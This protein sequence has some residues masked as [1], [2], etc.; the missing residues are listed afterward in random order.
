VI[1]PLPAHA[2]GIFFYTNNS[3]TNR[4]TQSIPG[5]ALFVQTDASICNADPATVG[6]VPVTIVSQLTG[7]SET[8]TAVE[9]GP[10]TG[11]FRILPSVPTANAATHIVASGDGILEV[12]RNDTVT[13]TITA[14]GGI[15]VSATTTLLVDPSAPSTTPRT[16][17][18]HRRRHRA[19]DRHHSAPA[20][21]AAPACPAVVFQMDGITPAPSVVVTGGRRFL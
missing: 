21:A 17:Q 11:I 16:N 9:T 5:N 12:L 2:A 20:T 1:L 10:N 3:Y 6:T 7:D 13:A 4:A 14:C 19:A 15:S 18:P 8:Y